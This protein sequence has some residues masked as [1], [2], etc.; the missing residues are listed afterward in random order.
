MDDAVTVATQRNHI[1]T[2]NFAPR[3]RSAP[4]AVAQVM[5]GGGTVKRVENA[6]IEHET[7]RAFGDARPVATVAIVKPLLF[8]S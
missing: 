8:E 7:A 1:P 2:G 3:D 5:H 6:A 4:V